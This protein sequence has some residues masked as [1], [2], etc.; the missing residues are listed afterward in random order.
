MASC[1]PA[2]LSLRG[3]WSHPAVSGVAELL[4]DGG[5]FAPRHW[6]NWSEKPV[7][8]VRETQDRDHQLQQRLSYPFKDILFVGTMSSLEFYLRGFLETHH[9]KDILASLVGRKAKHPRDIPFSSTISKLQEL[10]FITEG[11]LWTFALQLRN[12]IV[13]N[14][15]VGRKHLPSPSSIDPP[16]YMNPGQEA[17]GT[18]RSFVSLTQSIESS[19]FEAIKALL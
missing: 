16:I 8:L 6:T 12:D 10:N 4:R 15:S 11:D 18:L 19:Y 13:H 9:A 1:C 14:D 2:L 3:N 17:L 7:D 5:R